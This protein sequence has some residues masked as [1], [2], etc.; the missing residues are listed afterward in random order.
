LGLADNNPIFFGHLQLSWKQTLFD[1]RP[2]GMEYRCEATSVAGFV[3]QLA[4]A[5]LPHG[6][7]FYVTGRIPSAKDP[8][9]VDEKLIDKYGIGLSRQSRARRK[10][11]GIA[12]IHYLRY[13]R[14]FV[15][16]ATHGHHPFYDDEEKNIRDVR[17][18][19]I[20]FAGYSISCKRGGYKRKTCP[21]GQ[22]VPDDKWR[23]RV[24][25]GQQ[26]HRTLKAYFLD[27]ASRRSIDR[28]AKQFYCLPFEPYA[29]VRQQLLN[30]VRLV[31][32][33]RRT[34]GLEPVG[35]DVLRYRRNIVCPF[36]TPKT[37]VDVKA[38]RD[39]SCGQTKQQ[40][41]NSQI[42]KLEDLINEDRSVR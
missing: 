19:P 41:R 40:E 10:Q 42:Q 4:C 26:N 32:V 11:V 36:G 21:Q 18:V 14:F 16:L 28:L 24:Q 34:A 17:R 29:P 6:Y 27:V 38:S 35:Y 9:R 25:I 2:E 8:Q 33:Q 15:L 12:N 30:L 31:N 13:E 7:W 37:S 1:D 20:K 23:A 39:I 5:Y 3:Q 22:A